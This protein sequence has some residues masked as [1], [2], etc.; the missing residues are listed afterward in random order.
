MTIDHNDATIAQLRAA[1]PHISSW[2]SANAGSG[3][4][5]VL[6]SRVARLLIR[7]TLP[8][9]ILCLT[10][11]KAAAS[12]MQNR[13]FK[14]LGSWAMMPNEDLIVEMAKIGEHLQPD[15]LPYVRTLFAAAL[16]TPGGLKIQTIHSFA[17]RLLRQFPIEA[18]AP[19]N[20]NALSQTQSLA[21]REQ[22]LNRLSTDDP[23]LMSEFLQTAATSN[24]DNLLNFIVDHS[25][26]IKPIDEF[27]NV[28][29]VNALEFPF[30]GENWKVVDQLIEVLD[31][32]GSNDL[33]Y[34][35]YLREMKATRSVLQK[36]EW[37]AK[38]FLIASGDNGRP[39]RAKL[40]VNLPSLK[41]IKSK[42]DP[43]RFQ[44]HDL[45]KIIQ[46]FR[47][48]ASETHEEYL[49][50]IFSKFAT[51]F[52]HE[53]N[54]LKQAH[55]GLDFSDLI[56]YARRLLTKS[57]MR[58]W[59]LYKLD[60]GIDHILVDEAQDTSHAQWAI[61]KALSE[62]IRATQ[63]DPSKRSIFVVGDA[64]QSIFSFQ[65]ASPSAFSDMSN[66]FEREIQQAQNKFNVTELLYSFR[67][68][69]A[70]LRVV[71]QVFHDT[72]NIGVG[73]AVSHAAFHENMPGR[74]DIW[75]FREE[76]KEENK[77]PWFEP[78]DE[79]ARADPRLKLADD[80]AD[81]IKTQTDG[82]HFYQDAKGNVRVIEPRD[83]LILVQKRTKIYPYLQ[84]SLMAKNIPTAGADRFRLS[85]P[86][87]VQDVMSLLRFLA[88]PEDDLSLAEA[89]KSPLFNLSERELFDL[90]YPRGGRSLWQALR[91][92]DLLVIRDIL[93]ELRD[94]SDFIR[95]FE[96]IQRILI[97]HKGRE[98]FRARLG[99]EVDDALDALLNKALEF[100]Q[101]FP[102][103]L[104]HFI[105]FFDN[106]TEEIKRELSAE[107]NEVRI[108]TVH[109][110]KGLEAPIV[111]LAET[112][113]LDDKGDGSVLEDKETNSDLIWKPRNELLK[114]LKLREI[115]QSQKDTRNQ[116]KMRLLYVALTRAESWLVIAGA[117]KFAN[118][119][120][121]W[122]QMIQNGVANLPTDLIEG[123]ISRYEVGNWPLGFDTA[124]VELEDYIPPFQGFDF[125]ANFDEDQQTASILS[126]SKVEGAKVIEGGEA[127][128][129]ALEDG[130]I[131][132][133]L[134]EYLPNFPKEN[135][136]QVMKTII[137]PSQQH[138]FEMVEAILA[139]KILEDMLIRGQHEVGFSVSLNEN[140]LHGA[141]D[142]VV[143]NHDHVLIVDYKTNQIIPKDVD[144]I[145][146]G[147]LKQLALY[148]Y[149]M[150]P[151]YDSKPVLAAI[152]WTATGELMKIPNEMTDKALESVTFS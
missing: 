7:G 23:S 32:G 144:Q 50:Y 80:I 119:N 101:S 96:L 118:D 136:K 114:T 145:P 130:T 52:L 3:K 39:Y 61:I 46:N 59:V 38:V 34:A 117:G 68:S 51:K 129:S 65:G 79:P 24:F 149:A 70:I 9:R 35:K 131:V 128:T 140:I 73:G 58:A 90:A 127:N 74:V 102:P 89:L 87:A 152:L 132:H 4:T 29:P 105:H 20:F 139:D 146:E 42:T 151:H 134:L 8:E 148:V 33:K 124:S 77:N 60:G 94:Q 56:H 123:E 122:F 64:K 21:L 107:D 6:T 25:D 13:L 22:A 133:K 43:R 85:K 41:Y 111:I 36:L 49:R 19:V 17:D 48:Q 150:K 27:S 86:L 26:Q 142:L 63:V 93:Q 12:E 28:Q 1:D 81:W 120:S 91:Q 14:E 72:S 62:E 2:V 143:E 97:T 40:P 76:V 37:A 113:Q 55:G 115:E 75:P 84:T 15:K 16:E 126:P 104:E 99:G 30:S 109:G 78:I 47:D 44:F 137:E 108:M 106:E 147:L 11:T 18:G 88:L 112:E 116:E 10:F 138:L 45:S 98:N 57:E 71:D 54:Q 95:P 121:S 92:S 100:E 82:A 103:V 31:K 67:S 125:K 5:R 53:Y 135:R 83:I 110:A 141:I 66:L 69:P